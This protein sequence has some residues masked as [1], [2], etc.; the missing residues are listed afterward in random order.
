M[1]QDKLKRFYPK[2]ASL[3]N[4]TVDR[5][6]RQTID[7][8]YDFIAILESRLEEETKRFVKA[9]NRQ[10]GEGIND[11]KSRLLVPVDLPRTS[12]NADPTNSDIPISGWAVHRNMTSGDVFLAYNNVGTILKVQ[13]L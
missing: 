13:L 9:Q 11:V 3:N 6:I 10:T 5:E 4:P 7:R 1:P 8:I 2:L 12:S